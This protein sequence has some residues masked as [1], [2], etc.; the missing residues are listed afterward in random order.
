MVNAPVLARERNI[1]VTEIKHDRPA[2]ISR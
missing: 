2:T 1:E